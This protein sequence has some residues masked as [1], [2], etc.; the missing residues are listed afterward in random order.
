VQELPSYDRF[1][2]KAANITNLAVVSDQTSPESIQAFFKNKGISTLQIMKDPNGAS[3][4]LKISGIPTT[5]FID[6]KGCEMGRIVGPIH[7]NDLSVVNL[8]LTLLT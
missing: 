7:W 1:A 2:G 8:I 6:K 4:R 3:A 5:L